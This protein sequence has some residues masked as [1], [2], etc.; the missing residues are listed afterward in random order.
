MEGN[1]QKTSHGAKNSYTYRKM[2]FTNFIT[3]SLRN[4]RILITCSWILLLCA[5]GL[6]AYMAIYNTP[7][8]VTEEEIAICGNTINS[9]VSGY[10]KGHKLYTAN[11]ASCHI[12]IKNATGPALVSAMANRNAD[13]LC[14]H[15]TNPKFISKDKRTKELLKEYNGTKCVKATHLSC[16]DVDSLIVYVNAYR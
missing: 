1:T 2:V 10:D 3:M 16:Q 14:K 15:I 13:W 8:T 5:A 9:S 7:E 11:C 12:T 4:V 6:F